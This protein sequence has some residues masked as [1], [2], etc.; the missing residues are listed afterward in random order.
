[1]L[2]LNDNNKLNLLGN[3]KTYPSIER[4][5]ILSFATCN[6]NKFIEASKILGKFNVEIQRI[7]REEE[8]QDD[9]LK[10]IATHSLIKSLKSVQ[11]PI[12]VED[13]G[14]FI[15]TL[16]GFPGPYS[17]YVYKKLGV[18]AILKLLKGERNRNAEFKSI[19]AYGIIEE[20]KTLITT[21]SG[22]IK[23]RIASQSRG[24]GFG[25]DPIFVPNNE[26]LTFGEMTME[27]KN[28]LSH[29]FKSLVKFVNW[30]QR[31]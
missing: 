17:S 14:L 4:G 10:M 28:R 13:A 7:D 1:M 15:N 22:V 5:Q 12:I 9:D 30:Y 16:K 23:G 29:R 18:G 25:F 8:I 20:K 2:K 11:G 27:Q 21:F 6:R 24:T 31:R 26:H 19:I 3:A